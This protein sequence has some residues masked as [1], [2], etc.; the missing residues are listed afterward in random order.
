MG[1]PRQEYWRRLPFPPFWDLPNLEIEL[2]SPAVAGRFFTAKPPGSFIT[3]GLCSAKLEIFLLLSFLEQCWVKS[4][5]PHLS[6]AVSWLVST[7]AGWWSCHHPSGW[8]HLHTGHLA[9]CP[10]P[11]QHPPRLVCA[12]SGSNLHQPCFPLGLH[13]CATRGSPLQ[14]ITPLPH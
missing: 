5:D 1:F 4:M 11:C 2:A 9:A 8:A 3:Q 10:L 13:L 7:E 6:F 14:T 12:L